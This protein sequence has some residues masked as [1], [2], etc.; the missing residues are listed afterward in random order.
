MVPHLCNVN[1]FKHSHLEKHSGC[2][3]HQDLVGVTE[4]SLQCDGQVS[5]AG[6]D[7]LGLRKNCSHLIQTL[8]TDS[9]VLIAHLRHHVLCDLIT[10]EKENISEEL[11]IINGATHA[12]IE[13]AI[14]KIEKFFS[15]V[16]PNP[17]IKDHQMLHIFVAALN[18]HT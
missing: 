14:A 12:L 10:T 18:W 13:A 3:T 1:P 11:L 17:L 8:L 5:Q 16:F 4:A 2:N 7:E 9:P 15:T 6:L